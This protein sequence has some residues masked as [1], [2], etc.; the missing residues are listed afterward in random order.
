MKFVYQNEQLKL[1]NIEFRSLLSSNQ[2]FHL[3]FVDLRNYLQVCRLKA[4][5]QILN[6]FSSLKY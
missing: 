1:W 2:A 5:M 3:K 4:P 6:F